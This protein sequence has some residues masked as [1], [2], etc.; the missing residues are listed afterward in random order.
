MEITI[1]C[2]KKKL[3]ISTEDPLQLNGRP[4]PTLPA[5]ERAGLLAVFPL[6]S[7]FFT[8]LSLYI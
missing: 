6:A 5:G 8:F 7:A 3:S 4:S 1:N 2:K